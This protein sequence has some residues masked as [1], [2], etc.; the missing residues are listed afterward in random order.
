M[1]EKRAIS[2]SGTTI[3]ILS[4]LHLQRPSILHGTPVLQ[5]LQPT[6]E[7]ATH[8]KVQSSFPYYTRYKHCSLFLQGSCSI[9]LRVLN[10]PPAS[11][12]WPLQFSNNSSRVFRWAT[13]SPY[14]SQTNLTSN[15][16]IKTR[17]KSWPRWPHGCLLQVI[18][19]GVGSLMLECL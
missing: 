17:Q 2:V 6:V 3:P 5:H 1:S 11:Y 18:L 14:L 16:T 9:A 4:P 19:R 10:Q 12:H 15:Q 13:Y 7:L 8:H